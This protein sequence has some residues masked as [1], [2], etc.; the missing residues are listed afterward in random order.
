[1]HDAEVHVFSGSVLHQEGRRLAFFGVVAAFAHA[2]IDE[3]VIPLLPGGL[4]EGTAVLH[5]ALCGARKASRLWQRFLHD[6][7]AD[8]GWKASV[9]FASILHAK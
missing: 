2:L 8:A 3:L 6:V 5:K 4:G 9:I 7:V 1:M